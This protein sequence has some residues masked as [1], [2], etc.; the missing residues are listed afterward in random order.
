MMDQQE[1]QTFT[2]ALLQLAISSEKDTDW[3]ERINRLL[4]RVGEV[5][6]VILPELWRVGYYN[7]ASYHSRAETLEGETVCFLAKLA[8]NLRAYVLGGSFIEEC[9]GSLYNTAVLLDREGNVLDCYRK[10]HL[11]NYGSKER[12]ILSPG[13]GGKV[14]KTGLGSFGIAICYD[15][16]FPELFRE[17]S[18]KGAEVFLLPAAWPLSR[19]EAW[20]V[21]CRA[22]A[23]ENQAYVIACNSAGRGLLGRSMVVDPWGVKIAALGN[24]E[25]VLCTQI[26]LAAEACFRSEFPAWRERDELITPMEPFL[27]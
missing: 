1:Q 25:G 23:T 22:R 17:M 26:D 5:D 24:G 18:V 11:L 19:M 27:T 21:L 12:A 15:L 20:E 13:D 6:L 3:P 4:S 14:V 9:A 8:E 10:T 7:F 2:V 16:R